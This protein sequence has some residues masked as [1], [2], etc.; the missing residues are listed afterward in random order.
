MSKGSYRHLV[1][2]AG[3]A[4]ASYG[5]AVERLVAKHVREDDML[6]SVLRHTGRTRGA[7]GRLVSSPD[8]IG[9]ELYNITKIDITTRRALA[10]HMARPGAG[11]TKYVFDAG[12]PQNMTFPK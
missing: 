8:F 2:K 10:K 5:K 3:L 12:R 1:Q 6:S 7:G 9:T 4:D 11:G